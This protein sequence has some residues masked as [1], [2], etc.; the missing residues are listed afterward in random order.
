MEI[1]YLLC[2]LQIIFE[3]DKKKLLQLFF[4]NMICSNTKMSSRT[5]NIGNCLAFHDRVHKNY[6]DIQKME[7]K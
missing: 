1:T 6:T 4:L 7:S 5:T 2:F 3:E